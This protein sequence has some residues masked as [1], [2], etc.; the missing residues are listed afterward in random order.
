MYNS[1]KNININLLK[2]IVLESNSFV[3]VTIKLGFNP[4]IGHA[5]KN[6]ERLVKRNNI[7]TEHF[8]SV[9]RVREYKLRYDEEILSTLVKK[10]TTF[11]EILIELDILPIESNYVTLKKYLRKYN[12]DYSH[13]NLRRNKE[14]INVSF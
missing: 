8:D 6:I 2:K 9:Q 5:R 10:S 12:I 7:T 4:K 1:Y 3:D 14:F 11:K 13:I